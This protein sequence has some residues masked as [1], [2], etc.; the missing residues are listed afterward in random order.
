MLPDFLRSGM[1]PSE[2]WRIPVPVTFISIVAVCCVVLLPLA[3]RS[4]KWLEKKSRHF[5]VFYL[6]DAAFAGDIIVL[7]E[8]YY[9]RINVELG[10]NHVVKR[11]RVPWLG[12]KRCRIYLY[13]DHDEYV[14]VTRSPEWSGGVTSYT[15]RIVRSFSGSLDFKENILPH[16]MAHILFREYV[17]F[18]NL[19]VPLWLDEGVAQ[20]AEAGKRGEALAVMKRG[21]EQGTYVPFEELN[22]IQ[23][24]GQGNSFVSLFYMQ[25]ASLVH[26]LISKYGSGRFINFGSALRDGRSVERA[27]S[28]GV[29]TSF[30]SL[31]KFEEA[32]KRFVLEAR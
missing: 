13:R 2:S 20:Y 7:A 6:D 22:R 14:H 30:E 3:S 1:Q 4:E 32:W 29:S 12:D 23:I 28:S 16:E 21:L 27:L 25:S 11:D 15:E 19:R 24:G 9:S 26:F 18:N 31:G 17:G 8:Q 10:L 5:I